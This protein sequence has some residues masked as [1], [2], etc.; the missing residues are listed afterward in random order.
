MLQLMVERVKKFSVLCCK[1]FFSIL[2]LCFFC[3]RKRL[4]EQLEMV[5]TRNWIMFRCRAVSHSAE[6]FVYR[7]MWGSLKRGKL[8][9]IEKKKRKGKKKKEW[10]LTL[11]ILQGWLISEINQLPYC[12]ICVLYYRAQ[13]CFKAVCGNSK[14]IYARPEYITLKFKTQ[15][16]FPRKQRMGGILILWYIKASEFYISR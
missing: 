6:I 5:C 16:L 9:K 8:V 14:F 4:M 12:K 15:L 1:L 10:E 7:N 13:T 3:P 2:T 11:F